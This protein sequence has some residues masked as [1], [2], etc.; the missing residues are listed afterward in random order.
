M[1]WFKRDQKEQCTHFKKIGEKW[2]ENMIEII[3]FSPYQ[4]DSI[5]YGIS[6]CAACKKR[7]FSCIGLHMMT[8]N[9]SGII[10]SFIA[11]KIDWSTFKEFLDKSMA[12]YKE[13]SI[14]GKESV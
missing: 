1:K 2:P 11:H 4:T 9:E 7:A 5:G 13:A 10:D 6:E 8:D 14:N 3:R 12:W